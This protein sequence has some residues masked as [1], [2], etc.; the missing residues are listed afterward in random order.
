MDKDFLIIQL[1]NI[2]NAKR[3]NRLRVASIVLE[4]PHLFKNLLKLVF[5]VENKLSIK[6]AWV[7]ELVCIDKLELLA[8]HLS[9]YTSNIKYLK[10]DSSIRPASKICNFLAI[11]NNS[12]YD[13]LI[14]DTITKHQIDSI[15]ETS[16]DW[17]I[18]NQ[19]VAAKAY[20][21]N[22]L[23]LF[24]KNYDWVHKELKLIIQQNIIN[25]S[26]AYKARGKITLSLINNK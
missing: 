23:Y 14:K 18:S 5:E 21:M 24:G 16:F 15:I 17:M 20:A 26:S 9:Y 4:A 22:A 6:A 11:A 12:R 19:K 7:L 13:N 8:P 1:E 2:E 25:E 10:F 3:V